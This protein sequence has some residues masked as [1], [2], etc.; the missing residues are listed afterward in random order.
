M[1]VASKLGWMISHYNQLSVFAVG[2]HTGRALHLILLKQP[3]PQQS[4]PGHQQYN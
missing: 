3:Q 1:F 4:A 2:L